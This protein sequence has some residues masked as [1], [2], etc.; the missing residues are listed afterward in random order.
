MP[1]NYWIKREKERLRNNIKSAERI[2]KLLDKS[3]DRVLSDIENDIF[4]LFSKY[5]HD[6]ELSYS[7]AIKMLTSK[8]YAEFKRDLD[9]YV[10]EIREN[11]NKTLLFEL[12]TL[13]T[14]SQIS[15]LEKLMYDIQKAVDKDYTYKNE[16]IEDLLKKSVAE[17]FTQV[18][19]G[20]DVYMGVHNEFSMISEEDIS[21]II[22]LPWSGKNYSERLWKNRDKL[23]DVLEV[24]VTQG[25]IQ[26]KAL[27]KIIKD[28]SVIMDSSKNIT[29]RLVNTEHAYACEQGTLKMYEEMD[30]EKY[31]FLATLDIKT[32]NICRNLDGKVFLRK[33]AIAGVNYPPMHPHCRSTT[34][35]FVE[36]DSESERIARDKDGKNIYVRGD[37]TYKEWYKAYVEGDKEYLTKEKMYHN[38]NSDK[39]EYE[40]YKKAG[41]KIP[42]NLENF[43]KMKYNND[44]EYRNLKV[45]YDIKTKYNLKIHEGAQGKHIKGHN[46]YNGKSYLYDNIDLQGLVNK[47]SCTGKLKSDKKGNWTEK[48]FVESDFPIGMVVYKENEVKTNR[49]SIHYS[50]KKGTHIVPRM[51]KEE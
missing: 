42:K 16:M 20:I 38:R 30:V 26:G 2:S 29:R 47:F 37:I 32:S 45:H 6:N 7:E 33:D 11:E 25:L 31:Q 49:F 36:K 15:R 10:K 22:E 5:A 34:I 12:N 4:K 17:N 39:K 19:Y 13:S 27:E 48:E 35:P 3:T 44:K 21:K 51:P 43:Q 9:D 18:A 8:E 41:V 50:K 40:K 24:N 46:N 1:S 23:K 14:K 28:V